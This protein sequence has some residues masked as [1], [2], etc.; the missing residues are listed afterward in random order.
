[1]PYSL[2]IKNIQIS[3]YNIFTYVYFATVILSLHHLREKTDKGL[4]I[5]YCLRFVVS[6]EHLMGPPVSV[7]R[8]SHHTVTTITLNLIQCSWILLLSLRLLFRFTFPW[9]SCW[10]HRL[11]RGVN[12]SGIFVCCKEYTFRIFLSTV[13]EHRHRP[14]LVTLCH[15]PV[16]TFR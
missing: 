14:S 1:M 3:Q 16:L 2:Y 9:S 6:K 10:R 13:S 4:I 7:C 11:W 12:T 8:A 15:P 5:V